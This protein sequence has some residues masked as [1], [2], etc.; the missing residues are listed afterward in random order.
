VLQPDDAHYVYVSVPGTLAESI[1]IG[2]AVEQGE[3]LA[4]LKSL[5]VRREIAELTGQRNEQKLRLEHLRLRLA[6]DPG[7]GPQ[8]PTAEEA[9]RDIEKQLQERQRDAER[10]VL[11]APADGTVLPPPRRPPPSHAP[12]RL[13]SWQGS[14]LDAMNVGVPLETGTLFCL[15]GDPRRL[16]ALLVLDQGDV[17]F[18]RSGQR[19]R[20]KLD[21]LPGRIVEGTIAE[22]ARSD[23]KVAPR[24]LAGGKELA[25]RVDEQGIPR[26]AETSYQA[27]VALDEHAHRLLTGTGGRAKIVVDR[28][29]L[30]RRLYRALGR[31]FNFRL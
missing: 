28:Q 10:L 26:P 1:S 9:L 16:E 5:D 11:R 3:A 14:P 27:R 13:D 31:T 22:I 8:I 29:S 18:V 20:L 19:V 30:G 25:V 12:G 23:L 15:V 7:V 6:D 4:R 21:E 24:E 2:D 17:K